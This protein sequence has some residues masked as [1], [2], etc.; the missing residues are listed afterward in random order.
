MSENII[1]GSYAREES[2]NSELDEGEYQAQIVKVEMPKDPETG[3]PLISFDKN[4]CDVT[5]AVEGAKIK[6]RYS[7]SFG[8]NSQ[9]GSWA[10]FAE[11]IAAATGIP[12]GAKN[13]R[14]IGVADL[15]GQ[16]C[17]VVFK[18]QEK[19]GKSYLNVVQVLGPRRA[20][21][22][23]AQTIKIAPQKPDFTFSAQKQQPQEPDYA[24]DLEDEVPL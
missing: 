19:N 2:D 18:R 7:I 8:Q 15:E 6:R 4:V 23:A 9:T 10:A 24:Q 3:Q 5:F 16:E 21:R 14:R 1:F 13:Q 20:A 12:C 11:L 22:P 17:R